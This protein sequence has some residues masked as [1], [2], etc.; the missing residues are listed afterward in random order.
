MIK[1]LTEKEST[2]QAMVRINE[3]EIFLDA[4]KQSSGLCPQM[5]SLP[6]SDVTLYIHSQR[7]HGTYHK[8]DGLAE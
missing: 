6:Q 1:G 5:L 4:R 3:V 8:G 7:V 2:K